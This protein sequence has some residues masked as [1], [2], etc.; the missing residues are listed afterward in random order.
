MTK[1]DIKGITHVTQEETIYP[2]LLYMTPKTRFQLLL[3]EV[4]LL[5]YLPFYFLYDLN[6]SQWLMA[7]INTFFCFL[8]GLICIDQLQRLQKTP[9]KKVQ[10]LTIFSCAMIGIIALIFISFP[11]FSTWPM[12]QI[13]L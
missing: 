9:Q 13:Q 7:I 2:Q 4:P 8:F 11:W 5:W 12:Q 1:S 6:T 10:Y 3:F